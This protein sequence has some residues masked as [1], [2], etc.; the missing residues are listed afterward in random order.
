[1]I[2]SPKD[3]KLILVYLEQP[4][5][6]TLRFKMSQAIKSNDDLDVPVTNEMI[7]GFKACVGL[8]RRKLTSQAIDIPAGQK[9]VNQHLKNL[10]RLE[11]IFL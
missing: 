6:R 5:F 7:L 10:D 9:I 3:S 4:E 11:L 2:M 8:F 1:M